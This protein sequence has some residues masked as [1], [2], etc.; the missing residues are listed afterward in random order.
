MTRSE[1]I[2]NCPLLQHLPNLVVDIQ[3]MGS[4]IYV[5]DVSEAVHFL[6]YKP[7]ENQLTIFADETYQRRGSE[8]VSG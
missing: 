1:S 3:S 6:R 7:V 5:S 4:R 2:L 8:G